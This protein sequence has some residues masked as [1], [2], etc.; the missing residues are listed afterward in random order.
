MTLTTDDVYREVM[1]VDPPATTD[2]AEQARRDSL[3]GDLWAAPGLTRRERRWVTLVCVGFATDQQA[4]DEHFYAAMN[5]GDM[6]L[7]E[8]L[9]F[10]LHFAVYSGWPKA[11]RVEMSIKEQWTRIRQERGEEVTDWPEIPNE[12]LGEN[13]WEQR[14]QAGEKC[15]ADINITPAPARNTPYQQAGILNFVFGHLWQRPGLTQR[16]R[17]FITVPCVANAEAP[18]PILSHVGSALHSGDISRPEMD[19]LVRHYAAYAPE[20][21]S[22]ALAKAVEDDLFGKMLAAR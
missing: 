22:T 2:G 20:V 21:R 13:D 5:S 18:M 6:T 9:E 7:E 16:D 19:E 1:T 3:F 8:L 15:F 14:L 12:T 10:V 11:S 17:R 4:M